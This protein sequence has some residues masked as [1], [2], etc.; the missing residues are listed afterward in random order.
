M[1]CNPTQARVTHTSRKQETKMNKL[2][3][4]IVFALV[5]SN[6]MA[7]PAGDFPAM[8]AKAEQICAGKLNKSPKLTAACTTKAWPQVLKDGTRF[9]NVGIGAELNALI[10]N[11]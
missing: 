3:V 2:M 6:A 7:V 4:V 1:L 11:Q 9:Y 8:V 10:A 5:S